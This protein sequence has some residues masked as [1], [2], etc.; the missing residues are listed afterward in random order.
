MMQPMG[1][2]TY[3]AGVIDA[4]ATKLYLRSAC[5]TGS[6]MLVGGLVGAGLAVVVTAGA[7]SIPAS[8]N[9]MV[10]I[11]LFGAGLGFV[12]GGLI[13]MERAFAL[14]LRAHLALGQVRMEHHLAIASEM[15]LR[16][17]A[18][19]APQARRNPIRPRRTD[20]ESEGESQ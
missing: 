4:Y 10:A 1:K 7:D 13:G 18:V 8:R 16:I 17:G 19:V 15:L 9:A 6:S 3:D 20:F 2:L 11:L 14:R 12:L 5:I